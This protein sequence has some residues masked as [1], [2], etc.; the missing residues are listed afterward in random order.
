MSSFLGQ[1]TLLLKKDLEKRKFRMPGPHI[2]DLRVLPALYKGEAPHTQLQSPQSSVDGLHGG[3]FST[4][5]HKDR[6]SI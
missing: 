1:D 3:A 4:S 6:L 2:C 5:R